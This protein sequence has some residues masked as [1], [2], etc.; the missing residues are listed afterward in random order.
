M[1]INIVNRICVIFLLVLTLILMVREL[2]NLYFN[3]WYAN[4]EEETKYITDQPNGR[5]WFSFFSG[6][7]TVI[8]LAAVIVSVFIITNF[9]NR[10]TYYILSALLIAFVILSYGYVLLVHLPLTNPARQLIDY[11]KF[12]ILAIVFFMI[13]KNIPKKTIKQ[14]E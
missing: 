4:I 8:F 5:A 7:S 13:A 10:R 14:K 11:S 12:T 9:K 2:L 3:I 1:N 6:I